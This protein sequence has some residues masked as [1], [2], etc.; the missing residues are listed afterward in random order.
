MLATGA[1]ANVKQHIVPD[2]VSSSQNDPP[3]LTGGGGGGGLMGPPHR[4]PR[5][6]KKKENTAEVRYHIPP[7][8][9]NVSHTV[10]YR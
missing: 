9:S 10:L 8:N 3:L 6:T 7:S 4:P 5:R 1:T 2:I